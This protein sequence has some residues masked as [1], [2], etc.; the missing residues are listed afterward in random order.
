VRRFIVRSLSA[1]AGL[2]LAAVTLSGVRIDGPLVLL[3]AGLALGLLHALARPLIVLLTL[4]LT[5]ATLGAFLFLIDVGLVLITARLL[6][7]VSL[8]GFWAPPAVALIVN[9]ASFVGVRLFARRA[10]RFAR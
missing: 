9:V 1:A 2:G 3:E 4:P 6:Q 8:H 5:I 7:G 10:R